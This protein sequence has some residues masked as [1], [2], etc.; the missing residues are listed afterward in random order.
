[1]TVVSATVAPEAP[2]V[3]ATWDLQAVLDAARSADF[4][5]YETF[6]EKETYS[7]D[8]GPVT[9]GEEVAAGLYYLK[10]IRDDG[11]RIYDYRQE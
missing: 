2:E 1:M 7:L 3:L 9:D 8:S 11:Y 5:D 4:G 10:E 6:V